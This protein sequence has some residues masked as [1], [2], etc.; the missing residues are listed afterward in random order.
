MNSRLYWCI[1]VL[2][3]G[4]IVMGACAAPSAPSTAPTSAPATSV[5][6]TPE[7]TLTS[8]SA[9]SDTPKPAATMTPTAPG[10]FPAGVYKPE[11]KLDA[12]RLTF[13]VDGTYLITIGPRGI[14]GH[15]TVDGDK[16]VLNEDTGVCL[17]YPGTY[18]WQVQG[19]VLTLKAIDETC[20]GSER[21][22]DLSRTW[23]LL[24]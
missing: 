6:N 14:P 1:V 21:G 9:P 17:N 13:H 15:Y 24:P 8:I 16:I 2:M 18:N 4:S 22:K 5:P 11:Q 23:D 12:D 3:L 20:T 10:G 19:N 7:P